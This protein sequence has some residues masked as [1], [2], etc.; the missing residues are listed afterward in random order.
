MASIRY[1]EA[2]EKCGSGRA[3]ADGRAEGREGASGEDDS[4]GAERERT[5]GGAGAVGEDE[6]SE[7]KRL[8]IRERS[9]IITQL[10]D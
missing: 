7:E 1:G 5:E 4:G 8:N 6:K 10:W 9:R 3:R 2:K